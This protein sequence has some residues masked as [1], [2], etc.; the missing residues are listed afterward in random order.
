MPNAPSPRGDGVAFELDKVMVEMGDHVILDP[1]APVARRRELGKCGHRDVALALGRAGGPVDGDLQG[2]VGKRRVGIR[3]ELLGSMFHLI[4][5]PRRSPGHRPCRPEP[6]RCGSAHPAPRRLSFPAM[7]IRQPRS[8]AS[9]RSAPVLLDCRCFFLDDG[10]GDGRVLDTEG[11]AETAAHVI[12]LELPHLQPIHG[13]EQLARLGEDAE[14]AQAG[15]AIVI[16]GC[17]AEGSDRRPTAPDIGQEARDLVGPAPRASA[18]V[19]Q[20]GSPASA[21]G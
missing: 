17:R 2:P 10:V 6:R 4:R 19:T 15:T 3:L 20:A 13:G 7:F 16:G 9:R 14:F 21:S 1:L 8:P 11:P 18:R 12:A 5:P